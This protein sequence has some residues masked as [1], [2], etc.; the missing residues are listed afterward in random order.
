MNRPARQRARLL[1]KI[2]S[3]ET[4]PNHKPG[5]RVKAWRKWSEHYKAA[6]EGTVAEGTVAAPAA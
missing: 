5:K 4:R 1:E 3:K 6:A 2:A